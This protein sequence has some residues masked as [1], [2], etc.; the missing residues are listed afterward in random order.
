MRIQ[1]ILALIT[2]LAIAAVIGCGGGGEKELLTPMTVAEYASAVCDPIDL[3]DGATWRVARDKLQ[4]DIER[5][6]RVVPPA[7]VEDF[8]YSAMA[9]MKATLNAILDK[10]LKGVAN[11]Y[12]LTDN[13]EVMLKVSILQGAESNLDPETSQ[14]LKAAGCA[15]SYERR[16]RFRRDK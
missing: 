8:H 14:I 4:A 15:G 12:E 9:A 1:I 6:D 10:N 7:A 2:G 5:G 3:P 11:P 16:P 13:D